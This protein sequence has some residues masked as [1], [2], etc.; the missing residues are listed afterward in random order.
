MFNYAE[1]NASN[2]C[3]GVKQVGEAIIAADHIAIGD[4]DAGLIGQQWTGTVWEA[5][6]PTIRKQLSGT[7]WVET[8]TDNEWGS[9]KTLRGADSN[10]GRKLD[11]LMDAIQIT[12]S[13][14]LEANR[15]VRFYDF[16][17]LRGWVTQAR[18]DEL[19]AGIQET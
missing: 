19:Q 11:K 9:L 13:V 18:A 6:P 14:D 7:E 12:N 2:I 8:W 3:H 5:G 15:V 4:L 10:I 17:V 1:I 16:L